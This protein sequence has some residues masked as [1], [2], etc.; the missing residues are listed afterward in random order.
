MHDK[1]T[2][3]RMVV[4]ANY[5]GWTRK[6]FDESIPLLLDVRGVG[7]MRVAEHFTVRAGKITRLRQI[8]DTAAVRAAGLGRTP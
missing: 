2:D 7:K 4:K 1:V 6:R 8:H 3:T 5:R